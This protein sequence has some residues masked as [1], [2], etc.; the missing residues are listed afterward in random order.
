MVTAWEYSPTERLS[1][2]WPIDV[3]KMAYWELRKAQKSSRDIE[4]KIELF[5]LFDASYKVCSMDWRRNVGLIGLILTQVTKKTL[6]CEHDLYRCPTKS[7][8]PEEEYF[9]DWAQEVYDLKCSVV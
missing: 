4:D 5:V 2:F 6:I 7:N 1:G 8:S 9:Y 3:S